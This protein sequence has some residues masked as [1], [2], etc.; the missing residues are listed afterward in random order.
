MPL[1]TKTGI[2]TPQAL[3]RETHQSGRVSTMDRSRCRPPSGTN[4][5][6]SMARSA[7]SLRAFVS[8]ETNHWGVARKIRGA[9][10]RQ[11]CG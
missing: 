8:I 2:G 7:L 3:W 5:V 6:A 9:F 10:E 11:E 4:R 1:R